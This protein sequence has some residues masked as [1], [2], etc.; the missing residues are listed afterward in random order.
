MVVM[1]LNG[2]D[3]ILSILPTLTVGHIAEGK[4]GFLNPDWTVS[5]LDLLCCSS[6]L[7]VSIAYYFPYL[8]ALEKASVL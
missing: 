8:I 2:K 3:L 1:M 7:W 4:L 6:T 5:E